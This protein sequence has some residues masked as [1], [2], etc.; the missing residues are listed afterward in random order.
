MRDMVPK[1]LAG[2]ETVTQSSMQ[3]TGDLS[4]Q[5]TAQ[6]VIRIHTSSGGKVKGFL[7]LQRVL[8]GREGEI[9]GWEPT[10]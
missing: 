6:C 3:G 7:E 10:A 1:E 2:G 9:G 5:K 8:V 4:E